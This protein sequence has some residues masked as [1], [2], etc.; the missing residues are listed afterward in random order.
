MGY[1][2]DTATSA[3][4]SAYTRGM[5]D[6]QS[7]RRYAPPEDALLA[8]SYRAGYEKAGGKVPK[9]AQPKAPRQAT[10]RLSDPSGHA[11]RDLLRT[12]G[13]RELYR[14]FDRILEGEKRRTER[15]G[16]RISIRWCL[17]TARRSYRG[18]DHG[19]GDWK[20]NNNWAPTFAR[21]SILRDP[22]LR[23]RIELRGASEEWNDPDLFPPANP[24]LWF[25]PEDP[26][27]DRERKEVMDWMLAQVRP[28]A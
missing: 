8:E 27:R 24:Y 17:E 4:R 12:E 28:A 15:T 20:I 1:S 22:S 9:S 21:M 13:G 19:I 6:G 7:R 26:Y 2:H 18:P 3:Q 10:V 14:H 11:V 16:E 25:D 5:L 23:G